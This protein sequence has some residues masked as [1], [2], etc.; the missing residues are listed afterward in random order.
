M[1]LT[2]Y[3]GMTQHVHQMELNLTE[4]KHLLTLVDAHGNSL[5]RTFHVVSKIK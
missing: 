1:F 2:S 5:Q 3:A 4:G